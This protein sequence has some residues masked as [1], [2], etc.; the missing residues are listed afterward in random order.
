MPRL[1]W[2]GSTACRPP[3]FQSPPPSISRNF[4]PAYLTPRPHFSLLARPFVRPSLSHPLRARSR[5]RYR[6]ATTTSASETS[7][8]STPPTFPSLFCA[9]SRCQCPTAT[10]TSASKTSPTTWHAKTTFGRWVRSKEGGRGREKE[11]RRA[12]RRREAGKR[13][14]SGRC[15]KIVCQQCV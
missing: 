15:G 6:T 8:S 12:R 7:Q 2:L 10:M 14:V 3:S 4:Q 11:R 9:R 13:G 5:C 1:H